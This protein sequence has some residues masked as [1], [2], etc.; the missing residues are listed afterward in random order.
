MSGDV[1]VDVMSGVNASLAD[2]PRG[3]SDAALLG[4]IGKDMMKVDFLQT[5]QINFPVN[6]PSLRQLHGI[7]TP[8]HQ[9]PSS[10]L[11]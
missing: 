4:G 7:V 9:R 10:V 3:G 11:T 8:Q 1:Y 5:T 2:K 6:I